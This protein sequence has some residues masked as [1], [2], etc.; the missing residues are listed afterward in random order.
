MKRDQKEWQTTHVMQQ[1]ELA[2][3]LPDLDWALADEVIKGIR[4][5]TARQRFKLF[6]LNPNP[7]RFGPRRTQTKLECLRHI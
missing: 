1:T 5:T 6:Q 7:F 3:R 4:L 2:I